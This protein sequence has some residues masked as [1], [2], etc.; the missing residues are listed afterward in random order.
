MEH[1]FSEV[2]FAAWLSRMA[3]LSGRV[4]AGRTQRHLA[5]SHAGSAERFAFVRATAL[6]GPV[7]RAMQ[8]NA[9]FKD[10]AI[11]TKDQGMM[12]G[13]FGPTGWTAA[14]CRRRA[15]PRSTHRP[16][17]ARARAAA[18][19]SCLRSLGWQPGCGE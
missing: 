12:L 4:R 14:V 1:T 3:V 16:R 2:S 18:L 6:S 7:S 11:I 10:L 5:A 9:I 8:V 13:S 15:R 17:S 19:S